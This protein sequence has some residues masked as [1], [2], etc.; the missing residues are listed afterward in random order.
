V[1]TV[2]PSLSN[3]FFSSIV[4]IKYLN[5]MNHVQHVFSYLFFIIIDGSSVYPKSIFRYS[6]VHPSFSL[7]S[8]VYL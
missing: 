5:N 7:F 4:N 1:Q 2:L 6:S 8:V 3:Y